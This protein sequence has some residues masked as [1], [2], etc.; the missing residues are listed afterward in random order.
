MT[1]LLCVL[2]PVVVETAWVVAVLPRIMRNLRI[3]EDAPAKMHD[4][5]SVLFWGIAFGIYHWPL[6]LIGLICAA[7]GCKGRAPLWVHLLSFIITP[8]PYMALLLR[9]AGTEV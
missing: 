1:P 5:R 9:F 3:P 8:I 6:L 7:I 4:D 2:I